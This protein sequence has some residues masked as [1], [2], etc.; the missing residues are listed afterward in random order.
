MA[1]CGKVWRGKVWCGEVRSGE[2]GE[3]R[4]ARRGG[5]MAGTGV[6]RIGN[7]RFGKA[8]DAWLG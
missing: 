8:G 2:A 4:Q 3:E 6:D 5:V 1:R 7:G